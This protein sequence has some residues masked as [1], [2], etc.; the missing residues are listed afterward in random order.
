MDKSIKFAL[1]RSIPVLFGYLFLGTAIG[2]ML[3]AEGYGFIWALIAGLTVY[4][5][6]GE[7][8][9]VILLASGATLVETF[10]MTFLINSRHIFYGLSFIDKFKSMGKYY[11]Y[12]IF[13]LT[14]ETY[15]VLSTTKYSEDIDEKKAT[16]Y[17]ALFHHIYW[18]T[19]GLI[20]SI[21]GKF[22]PFDMYG[23]DFTMT[24]LFVV[25]FMEQWK[26]CKSKIPVYV[27]F[28]SSIVFF[29]LL[30]GE[31]FLLPSLIFTVG[32]LIIFKTRVEYEM[33]M[34]LND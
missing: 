3:R 7:F 13:S 19:G 28:I 12:M 34:I 18:V 25:L 22:I 21:I 15:S 6:S 20:G 14:D 23:I 17:I 11:P 26:T 24:A 9:L 5:G 8:L 33:G 27:G 2:I 31:K 30:G 16:F 1:K 32:L 29:I 10:I 4:A